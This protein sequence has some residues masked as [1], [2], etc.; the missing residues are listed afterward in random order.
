M[1]AVGAGTNHK[2]FGRFQDKC[3]PIVEA[4]VFEMVLQAD[5]KMMPSGSSEPF[6][7]TEMEESRNCFGKETSGC[8]KT[9]RP[10]TH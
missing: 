3:P 8:Q 7:Y 5:T 6:G 9:Y 10:S 4:F 2:K 1:A